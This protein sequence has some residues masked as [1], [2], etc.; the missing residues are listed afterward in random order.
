MIK[1]TLSSMTMVQIGKVVSLC[2]WE[3][4]F[5][6]LSHTKTQICSNS[7]HKMHSWGWGAGSAMNSGM[8]V[9]PIVRR[10]GQ[11]ILNFS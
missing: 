6:T 7:F 5:R 1:I 8:C 3:T 4:S 11:H 10:P 9:P 2:P